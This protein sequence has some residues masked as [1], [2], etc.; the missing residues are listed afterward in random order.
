MITVNVVP[1]RAEGTARGSSGGPII[2][3]LGHVRAMMFASNGNG[4][5]GVGVP[6]EAIRRALRS[7]GPAVE[8]G[9][10]I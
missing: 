7:A 1:Y 5:N 6:P 10:C 9:D 3:R 2:D 4:T 8:H